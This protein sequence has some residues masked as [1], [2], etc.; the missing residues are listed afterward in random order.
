MPSKFPKLVPRARAK[1][2]P[3]LHVHLPLLQRI[4]RVHVRVTLGARAPQHAILKHRRIVLRRAPLPRLVPRAS[5]RADIF[6]AF[7]DVILGPELDVDAVRLGLRWPRY[8]EAEERAL[9]PAR[10][11]RTA[12]PRLRLRVWRKRVV[13]SVM[14]PISPPR[15]SSSRIRCPFARPPIAGLQ[16]N[17]PIPE[18]RKVTSTVRAPERAAASAASQP[19]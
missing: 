6:A 3:S 7:E 5:L 9:A 15:A 14:R 18:A 17:S 11:P 4:P 13:R 2:S 19:A 10:V 16:L 12:G 8:F 1:R